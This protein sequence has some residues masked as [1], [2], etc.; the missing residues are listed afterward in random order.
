[1]WL[2]TN[3]NLFLSVPEARNSN[4]REILVFSESPLPDIQMA[5]F[6]LRSHVAEG[7]RVVS[8]LSF[9]SLMEAPPS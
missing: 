8:G 1:M 6:L 9:L 7:T 4:I 3:R 5:V 2:I